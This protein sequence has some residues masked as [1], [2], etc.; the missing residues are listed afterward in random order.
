MW[1]WTP[2]KDSSSSFVLMILYAV[3]LSRKSDNDFFFLNSLSRPGEVSINVQTYRLINTTCSCTM[4]E[5]KFVYLWFT[6]KDSESVIYLGVG[7]QTNHGHFWALCTGQVTSGILSTHLRNFIFKE[8]ASYSRHAR[9]R[10]V[11]A[12]VGRRSHGR[13]WQCM[14]WEGGKQEVSRFPQLSG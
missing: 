13:G 5:K 11:L 8:D 14:S 1:R 10:A 2:Q 12:T 4:I 9:A 7:L 6:L 3:I